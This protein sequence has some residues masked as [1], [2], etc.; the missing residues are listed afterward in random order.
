MA[1]VSR[2]ASIPYPA[3]SRPTPECLNPPQGLERVINEGWT[4]ANAWNEMLAHGF[5]TGFLG[6]DTYFFRKT[7]WSP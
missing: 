5:H 1:F 6:L 2:K 4:P 3:Y 7:N